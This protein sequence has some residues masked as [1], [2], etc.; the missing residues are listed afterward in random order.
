M[1]VYIYVYTVFDLNAEHM[2]ISAQLDNFCD[3]LSH[4]SNCIWFMG[5]EV[6]SC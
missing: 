3:F 6:I 4:L 1:Y 5:F 2:P